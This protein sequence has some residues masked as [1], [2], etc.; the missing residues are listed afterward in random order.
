M[1]LES[2]VQELK[3]P[4]EDEIGGEDQPALDS[5]TINLDPSPSSTIP[6]ST[7]TPILPPWSSMKWGTKSVAP[8]TSM[9][10]WDQARTKHKQNR[11]INQYD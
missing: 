3:E 8:R 2:S 1:V 10:T 6:Q 11:S 4:V 7:A 9:G 5:M